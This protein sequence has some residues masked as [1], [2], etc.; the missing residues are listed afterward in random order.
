MPRKIW[1]EDKKLLH[2]ITAVD[3]WGAKIVGWEGPV[4][5]LETECNHEGSTERANAEQSREKAGSSRENTNRATLIMM[6]SLR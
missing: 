5:P 4:D 2:A 1:P 3:T 6:R